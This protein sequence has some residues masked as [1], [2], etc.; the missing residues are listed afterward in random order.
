MAGECPNPPSNKLKA[1]VVAAGGSSRISRLKEVAFFV[2][3][4]CYDVIQNGHMHIR[5]TDA[6]PIV[7]EP[8]RAP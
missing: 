5:M 4:P 7:T 6:G 2:C 8:V 1:K 3:D